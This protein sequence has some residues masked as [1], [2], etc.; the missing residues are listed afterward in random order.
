MRL[1]L[2]SFAAAALLTVAGCRTEQARFTLVSTKNV[3]I[4]RVD[5][6]HAPIDRNCHES[7]GRLWFLFIPLG[8]APTIDRAMDSCLKQGGG[9][10]RA[11]SFKDRAPT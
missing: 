7:D 2:W 8:S 1:A 4:S 6:K 11:A 3:E 10:Y 5:L 9:V